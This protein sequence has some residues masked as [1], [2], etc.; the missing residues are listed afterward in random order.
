MVPYIYVMSSVMS[1]K[2]GSTYLVIPAIVLVIYVC[3]FAD[4]TTKLYH[5]LHNT[6]NLVVHAQTQKMNLV[7]PKKKFAKNYKNRPICIGNSQH[8][9]WLL[10]SYNI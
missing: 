5:W 9:A 2:F 8:C 3:K 4:S 1:S 6:Y 10:V 7:G